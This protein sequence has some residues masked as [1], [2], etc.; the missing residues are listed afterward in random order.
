M[1]LL[2]SQHFCDAV[3][4]KL[5]VFGRFLIKHNP[6]LSQQ[7]QQQLNEHAGYSLW[8]LDLDTLEWKRQDCNKYFEV[9]GWNYFTIIQE[10]QPTMSAAIDDYQQQQQHISLD[11]SQVVTHHLLFL[12]NTDIARTQGYDHFRDALIINGESLGVFDIS[13]CQYMSEFGQMLDNPEFSDFTIVPSTGQPIYVHQVILMTRWPHFRNVYKSGMIESSERRIDIPEPR[14]VVMAFLKYLYSDQLDDQEPWTVICELLVVANMYLQHRLK[15]LCCHRLYQH[16]LTL[17][18]CAIIYE[19]ATLSDEMGLKL[20]TLDFMYQ[21]FG[22][23]LKSNV[24]F[25]VSPSIQQ[26]FFDSV[27]EEATLFT[28]RSKYITHHHHH[29]NNNNT[30]HYPSASSSTSTLASDLTMSTS[31]TILPQQ[32]SQRMLSLH[33]HHHQQQQQQQS[34][35]MDTDESDHSVSSASSSPNYMTS[36]TSTS[37]LLNHTSISHQQQ[38]MGILGLHRNMLSNNST[39]NNNDSNNHNDMS[40]EV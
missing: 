12:G 21:H 27:P 15:K 11:Q 13:P 31:A 3:C 40:V 9:G 28:G 14:E 33:H 6:L 18:S 8:M 38:R 35:S 22:S 19:K 32:Y 29:Q 30:S 25:Q 37:S 39:N 1:A 17:E 5:F 34:T 2:K 4:G 20:L 24:L 10:I 36:S 7:Q 26:A 16:H 23:V